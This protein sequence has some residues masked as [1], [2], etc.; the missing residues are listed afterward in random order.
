MKRRNLI[1]TIILALVVA[2]PVAGLWTLGY[3][4]P[5]L[6]RLISLIPN[7][8]GTLQSISIKEV[9][10]SLAGGFEIGSV[11]VE[12]DIVTLR[13]RDLRAR[14]EL[15]PLLWQSIEAAELSVGE[16]IIEQEARDLPPPEQA[17][18]FLP[19]LLTIEL[20]SAEIPSLQIRP[21]RGD[22]LVIRD[23]DLDAL[24]RSKTIDLSR[25]EAS[26]GT[27]QLDLQGVLT[28][29]LPLKLSGEIRAAYDPKR[30]PPWRLQG[31]FE[32]DLESARLDA[33][34]L[35]PFDAEIKNGTMT[36]QAPWSVRGDA[37]VANLDLQKFGGS[38]FLGLIGGE[39]SIVADQ[40]GYRANG[41]LLPPGLAAGPLDVSFDGVFYRNVLTARRMTIAHADSRLAVDLSGTFTP[42]EDGPLLDLE[43]R[44]TQLRWPL[45]DR[46]PALDSNR[47]RFKLSGNGPYAI[48]AVADAR[49]G[50]LPRIDA[51]LT[52]TLD[53]GR[54]ELTNIA[55]RALGGTA[56]LSGE[57]AWKPQERWQI[58]GLIR[59]LN[60][61]ELRAALPGRL[62]FALDA[63]GRGFGKGGSI[64]VDIKNI[65]GRLRG[66]SARGSGQLSI[67]HE[68]LRFKDIDF[69]AGGLRLAL[70]GEMSPRRNDLQF[71]LFADDLGVITEN[72]QG[73]LS[74]QGAL[75]GSPKAMKVH[76]DAEGEGIKL[77][78]FSIRRLSADVDL[79]PTGGA[80]A[81][82][83]ARI[84]AD[85]VL[86]LG[87]RADRV[88]LDI[89]GRSAAHTLKIDITGEDLGLAAKADAGFDAQGWTQRWS[90]VDLRLPDNILLGLDQTLGLQLTTNSIS[91]GQFCLR[92]QKGSSL[93]ESAT[94]C[95]SG[96][97]TNEGWSMEAAASRLPIA[98]L[99]PPPTA[100]AQYLGSVN[101]SVKLRSG[102]DGLP[103]GTV[104]A[105]FEGAGLRWQR[106]GGR[107][108][109]IPLGAGSLAFDSNDQGL[110]GSL[111]VAADQR[112]RAKGEL[113]AIRNPKDD[114]SGWRDLPITATLRADSSALALL[115]LYVP[116]IDRSAGDLSLDLIIGGTLGAPLVNGVVRLEKGELDFYQ[117]NLALRGIRAEARLLDNG[118]VLDAS[119]RA[120]E[121]SIQADA[122]LTW[123]G[124]QPY[125]E[126]KIKGQDLVVVD[127]PEAR[128]TASPDLRFKVADRDLEASGTVLI[129]TARI[130]PA[131]LTGA[132]LT[133]GDARLVGAEPIDPASSF[134][135]SS[136]LR[137]TL[138]D[139]VTLDSFGLSG[140]LAGSLNLVTTADG[141]S[142]GTGELG[143]AEGK[144]AAL[145]R[146]LDIERGRLIFSGGLLN[147]PGVE[148]RATKEFP[149]VRAGVNVRGSLREPRMTFFSEPA[150]PQ[151][152]VVSLILAGGTLES[153]QGGGQGNA[154][155]DTLLAQ[156]GAILAQQLGQRIGI[157]DV[158]IEQNLANETSLVFGRYL[159]SR[160]YVSYGVSLAEAINTLKLRYSINDRWT[161][162][163]EAGKESSAEVVYTVEKN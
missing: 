152:Q 94:I 128:I 146:R 153:T 156:G 61:G 50:V 138:G 102:N 143:V 6:Q 63:Q 62:N 67:V 55:V 82:A 120:G 92:G 71:R 129:P 155:R 160:L 127:V 121:G 159:S 124:G 115:Y 163:T 29:A 72:G 80:E 112:G 37:V 57:V 45:A 105:D 150:L 65:T 134:R 20:K 86:V 30:G 151:S 15:L 109:V 40:N 125:G 41:K 75:R 43:G 161:L 52:S 140:R 149:D 64:S 100:K 9:R 141:T 103:L 87:R 122:E 27:I 123:R 93:T 49:I 42:T 89:A 5:A 74:A 79:D 10:G 113:R 26:L 48:T 81:S 54:F 56:K 16:V 136:N 130:T 117:V 76:L 96:A 17:R 110:V 18:P 139:R 4:E 85:D 104:R 77:G 25:L 24:I 135:V 157:E 114:S 98:S 91:V 111:D 8:V 34:L 116:E 97:R 47:G 148:I 69:S 28:A 31:R 36:L 101:A 22:P 39:V 132:T 3:S 147:D 99:L 59:D 46:T 90:S 142:R 144:Y 51:E 119:A 70:D 162:R 35:E 133:S 33:N 14:I 108:D 83:S 53:V 68:A 60:P 23:I 145:G 88:R 73:R 32:G 95:A 12:H 21:M 7:K 126:L 106:A 11:D 44:W 158:G 84:E 137:L 1:I 131:D 118:F 13:I 58:S 107:Q 154:G 19:R 38:A 78:D 66:A 2:L